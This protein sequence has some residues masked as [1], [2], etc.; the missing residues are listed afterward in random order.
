MI[1][2]FQMISSTRSETNWSRFKAHFQGRMHAMEDLEIN[3]FCMDAGWSDDWMQ[4][5]SLP[6]GKPKLA[7]LLQ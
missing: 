7:L 4:N 2:A 3:Q 6:G 5:R 1:A